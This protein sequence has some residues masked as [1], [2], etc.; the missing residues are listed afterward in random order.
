M[1]ADGVGADG[2]GPD[3][4]VGC[5]EVVRVDVPDGDEV[6][7]ASGASERAPSIRARLMRRRIRTRTTMNPQN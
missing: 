6:A 2:V 5:A 3:E 7:D 1:G 4:S